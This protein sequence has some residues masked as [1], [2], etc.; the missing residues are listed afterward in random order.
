MMRGGCGPVTATA[1]DS[2]E[3]WDRAKLQLVLDKLA[4]G[5]K[6]TYSIGW[7]WWALFCRVRNTPPLRRVSERCLQEEEELFLEFVVHLATHSSKAVGTIKQYLSA[8]RAQHLALGYPEPTGAMGR[9]WMAI[10][11]LKRRQGGPARKKPVTPRM[12]RWIGKGMKP[13]ASHEDAMLWAAT[14]SSSGPASRPA[15]T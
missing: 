13:K 5:T 3:K 9:L 7:R 8:I 11:G 4:D 1:L 2:K 12:L 10:D 6:K 14:S 15:R